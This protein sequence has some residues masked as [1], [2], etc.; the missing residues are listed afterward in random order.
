MATDQA[1]SR[2]YGGIHFTFENDAS[3]EACPRVAEYAF[4]HYMRPRG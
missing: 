3:R 2:V 1:N 4:T